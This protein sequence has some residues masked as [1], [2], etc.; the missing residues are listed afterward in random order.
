M[1][2]KEGYIISTVAGENVVLPSGDNLD[3]TMMITLN[4]T[5]K[6]LWE[7]LQ[8]EKTEE[9]LL[10]A[11]IAAYGDVD[12][13]EVKGF[14]SDFVQALRENKLLQD[15]ETTSTNDIKRL[16]AVLG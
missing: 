1:K 12:Q 16:G 14:I 5:G 9:E 13:E 15:S 8:E 2:I 6:F 7:Q 3:L 4:D 11:V 10:Q